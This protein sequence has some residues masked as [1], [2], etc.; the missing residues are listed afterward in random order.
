MAKPKLFIDEDVH[1]ELSTA[2]IKRG[3]DSIHAQEINRKGLPDIDQL[4]YAVEM[5]RCLFTFN[6]KD[7]VLLHNKFVNEEKVHYGIIV[8][9]QLRFSD[10]LTRVLN[11]LQT[12]TS[13]SLKNK[14]FFL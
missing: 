12:N 6:V 9:K 13:D 10:T 4:L 14:L 8:S 1:A 5:G 3:Y 2:L 7:F 11:I